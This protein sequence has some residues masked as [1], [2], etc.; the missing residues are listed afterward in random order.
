MLA[1]ADGGRKKPLFGLRFEGAKQ[2]GTFLFFVQDEQILT[3]ILG[4]VLMNSVAGE[5]N[6]EN[7]VD[8]KCRRK[9]QKSR[10]SKSGIARFFWE[11]FTGN[12]LLNVVKYS[13]RVYI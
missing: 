6:G 7:A 3:K 2:T 12:T 8:F 13:G 10:F 11:C 1:G 5:G 4:C 9:W